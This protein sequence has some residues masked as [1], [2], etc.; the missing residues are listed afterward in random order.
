[1]LIFEQ[2]LL[3]AQTD[4]VTAIADRFLAYYN[5]LASSGLLTVQ[6]LGLNVPIYDPSAYYNAVR[7]APLTNVSPQGERLDR[8]LQ[9]IGRN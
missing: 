8:V 4:R 5:I 7:N 2:D 9:S 6:N 1:V 3:N